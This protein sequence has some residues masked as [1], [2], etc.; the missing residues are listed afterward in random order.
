MTAFSVN[1][2]FC[3]T[4]VLCCNILILLIKFFLTSVILL[5][6]DPRAL[7]PKQL[8]QFF[9][10]VIAALGG[11]CLCVA[12]LKILAKIRTV[13]FDHTIGGGFAT[14]VVGGFVVEFAIQTDMKVCSARKTGLTKTRFWIDGIIFAT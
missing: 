13:F 11:F 1:G 7:L 14:F 12:N 5:L 10:G 3:M 2:T 8:L 6:T 9:L 4:E